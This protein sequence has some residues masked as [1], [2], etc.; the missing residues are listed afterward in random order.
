MQAFRSLPPAQAEPPSAGRRGRELP[1]PIGVA[2][3]ARGGTHPLRLHPKEAARPHPPPLPRRARPPVAIPVRR[4][5]RE[6]V[7]GREGRLVLHLGS[8]V[9]TLPSAVSRGRGGLLAS[10][11]VAG[12]QDWPR[13]AGAPSGVRDH[14]Y[15]SGTGATT[16]GARGFLCTSGGGAATRDLPRFGGGGSGRVSAARPLPSSSG[17]VGGTQDRLSAPGSGACARDQQVPPGADAQDRDA[18]PGAAAGTR[19]GAGTPGAPGGLSDGQSVQGVLR[20]R[21]R[22]R[23]C[24]SGGGGGRL[25]GRPE[26]RE[27]GPA[28]ALVLETYVRER[29]RQPVGGV[30]AQLVKGE[31]AG[32]LQLCLLKLAFVQALGHLHRRRSQQAW[33]ASQRHHRLLGLH[34]GSPLCCPRL[35]TSQAAIGGSQVRCWRL[36]LC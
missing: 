22:C 28:G 32:G 23:C 12:A 8:R 27:L 31:H 10:G 30:D 15:T 7:V 26:L 6:L 33:E 21:S 34:L 4:A 9:A 35:S 19:G 18:A 36:V 24:S 1:A 3:A 11:P 17:A 25:H 16:R 13:A 14:L 2:A 29:G 20:A 5:A